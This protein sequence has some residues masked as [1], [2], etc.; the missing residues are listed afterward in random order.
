M[1]LTLEAIQLR[2]DLAMPSS[3]SKTEFLDDQIDRE[4]VKIN[5][6]AMCGS[7]I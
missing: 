6:V 7:S 5:S 4:I 2:V 1:C 3:A